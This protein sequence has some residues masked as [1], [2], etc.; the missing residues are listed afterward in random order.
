[1][2]RRAAVRGL[3]GGNASEARAS[4]SNGFAPHEV[5]GSIHMIRFWGNCVSDEQKLTD[6]VFLLKRQIE[7]GKLKF[8][9]HLFAGF[10]ESLR[11]IKLDDKGHV[12]P[13]SVDGR[14]RATLSAV[15]YFDE[16]ERQKK[17]NSLL[18]IQYAY[19]ETLSKNFEKLFDFMNREKLDPNRVAHI[20]SRDKEYVRDFTRAVD[21]FLDSIAEFWESWSDVTRYHL[22]DIA[23]LKAS[24]GGD[25]FPAH[26]ESIVSTAG[27]YVDTIVLPCPLLKCA[28]LVAHWTEQKK[29][30]FV[31]KH[32][33]TC[34]TYK[35]A[36]LADVWPPIVAVLPE[37]AQDKENASRI[38]EVAAARHASELFGKT[39]SSADDVA[40]F[41]TG[42]KTSEEI[43][44]ALR[45]SEL[46]V[47][48]TEW[49]GTKLDQLQ[50]FV[51]EQSGQ[52]SGPLANQNVGMTVFMHIVG[53]MSQAAAAQLRCQEIGSTPI[54]SAETSW[55]HYN[56]KIRYDAC[57]GSCVPEP[58]HVSHV[59]RALEG[60]V[61]NNL[62][63][64][65]RVPHQNII[66]IRKN[67]LGEEV[68]AILANG[69]RPLLDANPNN[70][71]RT[72]DKV[73]HNLDEAFVT[74]QK[75]LRVLREK[76][77]RLFGIDVPACIAVG[78]I[79]IGAALTNNA[80]LGALSGG[81]GM[82]GVANLKDIKS[83][84]SDIANKQDEIARSPTG[85]LFKHLE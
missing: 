77:L 46:L 32:A 60:E 31:V 84:Y 66:E 65:G 47:F 41:L 20:A 70:F 4:T 79:A 43:I 5:G 54:I 15:S 39:F 22:Q 81:L 25:I 76:K 34:L 12:I 72:A 50:R 33:L 49:T 14:V 85:L 69:L 59:V 61:D 57:D 75:D 7:A 51:S 18:D 40:S 21:G 28:P 63:W 37:S 23:G 64:L 27:L 52:F 48:N 8:A 35:G 11:A 67:G 36:A 58:N 16:R 82:L 26:Q 2:P 3:Y 71:H 45:R 19:F 53:R 9:D 68:R 56:W 83:R 6:R 30:Y 38:S 73:I 42:L 13:S 24:F 29:I 17:A 80:S 10:V 44:R 55:Q 1:M 62:T 78:S 74:H